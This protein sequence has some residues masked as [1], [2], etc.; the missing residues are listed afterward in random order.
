MPSP[1]HHSANLTNLM[2]KMLAVGGEHCASTEMGTGRGSRAGWSFANGEEHLAE[3][4]ALYPSALL[5][6]TLSAPV[7]P[8][9]TSPAT[10]Y[11]TV[12]Y[13]TAPYF[14][15]FARNSSY[16]HENGDFY[17]VGR[18]HPRR[19]S[20]LYRPN[21]ELPIGQLPSSDQCRSAQ[22]LGHFCLSQRSTRMRTH[23]ENHGNRSN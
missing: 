9:K 7:R 8:E 23:G 17:K 11:E 19:K 2:S 1:D 16:P 5:D 15:C 20:N 18:G 14:R 4:E 12:L 21:A 10:P 3:L 13:V 22:I 6:A